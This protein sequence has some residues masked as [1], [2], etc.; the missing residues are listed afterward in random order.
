MHSHWGT[1]MDVAIKRDSVFYLD[2]LNVV[3]G[4]E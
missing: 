2:M 3:S 4:N 1:S